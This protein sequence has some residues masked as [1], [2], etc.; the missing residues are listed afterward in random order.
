MQ[1]LTFEIN[2]GATIDLGEITYNPPRD[3][4]TIWEIGTPDRTAIGFYVP[5]PN[6]LYINKLYLNTP[7]KWVTIRSI[8]HQLDKK[9]SRKWCREICCLLGDVLQQLNMMS[10]EFEFLQIFI[11]LN[12]SIL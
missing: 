2:A 1:G 9:L 12:I 4:A 8:G 3:G 7:Q 5:D 10:F 6:P 11:L